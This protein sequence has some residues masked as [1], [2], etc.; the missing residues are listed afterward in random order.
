MPATD[1][2]PTITAPMRAILDVLPASGGARVT[3]LAARAALARSTAARMLTALETMG[4]ARRERG[5]RSID[6]S[7]P[8]LW[9]TATTDHT[10]SATTPETSV[11]PPLHVEAENGSSNLYPATSGDDPRPVQ[12]SD[13]APETVGRSESPLDDAAGVY[14]AAPPRS[15]ALPQDVRETLEAVRAEGDGR[16]GVEPAVDQSAVPAAPD[17]G[18]AT[19]QG[20]EPHAATGDAPEPGTGASSNAAPSARLAKGGLR[21]LVAAHLTAYPAQ[22]FTASQV[23][24]ALGK[25]S[26]AVANCFDALV[27]AGQAEMTCEKPRRF[28]HLATSAS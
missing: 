5:D 16:P 14:A 2:T 12:A 22:E 21:A 19:E 27:M 13:P 28:R 23:G 18:S 1:P 20:D 7:A 25:S 11:E 6:H 4:L 10:A 3:D 15:P 8:D 24:K 17:A 9:F 26:G